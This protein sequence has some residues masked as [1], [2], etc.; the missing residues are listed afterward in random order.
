LKYVNASMVGVYIYLQPLLA[1][2]LAVMLGKDEISLN[3]II[4]ALLIF[5]GVYLVSIKK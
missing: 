1:T 5:S 2:F 4:F 3:K